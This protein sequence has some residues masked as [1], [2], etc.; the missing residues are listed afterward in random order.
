MKKIEK[1]TEDQIELMHQVKDEWL[2]RFFSCKTELNKEEC[3]KGV[4]W[5]Y[6]LAGYK[7]PIIIF[8]DSPMA[9]PVSYTH[10]TLPT[11]CSV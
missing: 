1:L 5:M 4:N 6:Q 11:I 3:I 10:L 2:N 9:A 7:N 8:V